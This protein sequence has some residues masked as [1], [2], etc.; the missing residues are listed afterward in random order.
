MVK[1]RVKKKPEHMKK[2]SAGK[3]TDKILVENFVALQKVMTNLSVSFDNLSTR[4]SKLLDLFE[5]SAKNLAGKDFSI[6]KSNKNEKEI[7]NKLNTLGDQNKVIARGLTLLH[8]KD[9]GQEHKIV[10]ERMP[11]EKIPRPPQ[12][13]GQRRNVMG[14]EYQKSISYN[15]KKTE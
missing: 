14:G 8:E 6:E 10:Q 7:L 3:G 5:I 9:G 11:P 2:T 15:P 12:P 13:E 1:K 4:I